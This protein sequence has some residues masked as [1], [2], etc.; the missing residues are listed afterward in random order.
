[1]VDKII[2]LFKLLQNRAG[3]ETW[4]WWN[5]TY[6]R[7]EDGMMENW[8]ET[9]FYHKYFEDA[10]TGKQRTPLKH[11]VKAWIFISIEVWNSNIPE[12]F[13]EAQDSFARFICWFKVSFSVWFIHIPM[14]INT[15]YILFAWLPE[16]CLHARK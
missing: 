14:M 1:M 4:E 15:I 8:F 9:F 2:S 11:S 7:L 12:C 16:C 5:E 3:F 10:K 6:F 13:L